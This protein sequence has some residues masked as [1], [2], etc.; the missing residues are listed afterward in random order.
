MAAAVEISERVVHLDGEALAYRL[1]RRRGRRHV[2]LQLEPRAGL[3]VLAPKRLALKQVESVLRQ[4]TAWLRRRLAEVRRWEAAHPPRRFA[5]GETLPLLGED[6]PLEAREEAG[7]RRA[8]VTRTR[9]DGGPGR[10]RLRLP[11][12]L[13]EAER[14]DLARHTLEAWYRRL[15]RRLI[16]RRA[17]YWSERLGVEVA[18]ISVRDQRTRWGSCS[19]TGRLSFSWRIAMAPPAVLDYLV[20]H[21][22]AH[23]VHA[24]HSPA[25]WRLVEKHA[26]RATRARA[27]L[28]ERGPELY[29]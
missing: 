11:A 4:E 24:D 8:S 6:W 25:F 3:R 19:S 20:V 21:E 9:R 27:W 26:P 7:R 15:A 18:A 2:T 13:P 22:L 23:R 28:R 16:E 5:S 29:L 10:I 17:S 12:G 14:A 1:E